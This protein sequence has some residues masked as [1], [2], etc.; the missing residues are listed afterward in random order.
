METERLLLRKFS[1]DDWPDLYEY[2]SQESV[3]KYQPYD[4]FTEEESRQEAARRAADGH[5]WAVCLKDSGKL[6]G[7]MYLAE[8]AFD[9]WEL[10]CAFNEHFQ[11]KGYAMEA[12]RALM[13]EAFVNHNASRITAKCN[14]L[15]ERAWK[16]LEKLG[17]SRGK[18]VLQTVYFK[19]DSEGRPAWHDTFVYG[20]SA[21]EW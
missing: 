18:Y 20:I 14:P 15:N 8:Q 13:R 16:L 9:T 17:M 1:P 21:A 6:I 7:N 2:L 3:V 5:Y 4:V 10:G 11:G 19:K 12:V